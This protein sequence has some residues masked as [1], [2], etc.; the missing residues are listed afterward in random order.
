SLI[1]VLLDVAVQAG[2][3]HRGRQANVEVGQLLLEQ[4]SGSGSLTLLVEPDPR[5]LG[6]QRGRRRLVADHDAR[7]LEGLLEAIGAVASLVDPHPVMA[8]CPL[9]VVARVAAKPG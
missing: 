3:L 6:E 4:G 1:S 7:T 5:Q 2:R 9:D 8:K